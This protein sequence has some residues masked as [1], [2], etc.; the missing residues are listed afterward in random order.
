MNIQ[1]GTAPCSWG[2]EF[3]EDD[4]QVPWHRC[5]MEI[6]QAGYDW[7]ELGP[8]GYVPTDTQEL[9]AA[10]DQYGLRVCSAVVMRHFEDSRQW[11]AIEDEVRRAAELLQSVGAPHIV[12]IDDSYIDRQSGKMVLQ[13]NLSESEFRVL[14]EG[15][16]RIGRIVL[17]EFGMQAVFHPHAETHVQ[18]EDQIEEYIRM[19][20]MNLV[21]LAFDTG[22]HTYCGS[23]PISFFRRHHSS[24]RY[25]HIKSVDAAVLRAVQAND[26]NFMEAVARR[27]FIEPEAGIVDFDNF[28]G[29]LRE[30]NYEGFVIVEQ[31]MFP[32]RSLSEPLAVATCTRQ[33]LKDKGWG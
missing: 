12:L 21:P 16:E 26:I 22:H 27:V 7:T 24:I 32:V 1:I 13:P 14:I 8:Y 18:S 19:A 25:L 15:V 29:V 33:W 6:A 9:C 28:L 10:L 11:A 23:D 30:I 17:E 3:P 20:D 5:L 4:R 2:V 31:D